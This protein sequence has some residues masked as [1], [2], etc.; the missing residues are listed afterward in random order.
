TDLVYIIDEPSVGLHPED[1]EKINEIM[2]S[3]RDKGNTVP[4]VE[5]DPDVIHIADHVIDIGPG[6]GQ[7]GGEI[8]FNGTY[9]ELMQTDTPTSLALNRTHRLKENPRQAE[10]FIKLKNI[11]KNNLK[12]VSVDI[13]ADLL[14]V[15]TGVA[16]SGKSTLIKTGLG[17]SED[18]IF[19]DQK[20]VQ[21]TSRPN[22]LTYM[23]LFD[24]VRTFFSKQTGLRKSMFSYNSEGACPECNGKGVIKTELAFMADFSQICEVC[25]G[26]RYK[27][28]VLEATV[29]GYSIADVLALTV[30]E[31]VS[32][33]KNNEKVV[34]RLQNLEA[35]GLQYMTL[36]Q[37]LDTLSGGEIQRLKLSRY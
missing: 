37:S 9:E 35:T 10:S 27:K 17:K 30:E 32:L 22:L 8:I 34:S 2:R 19:I 28:E 1:I 16:G 6:A 24:E 31:A 29:N 15:V 3:I 36:G 25:N 33:F 13:P 7:H 26:T 20:A 23:D 11:T 12:D 14:S 21:T 5:H 4:I 18:A